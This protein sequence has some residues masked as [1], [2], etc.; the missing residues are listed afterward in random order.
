MKCS[1]W[2]ETGAFSLE[3]MIK[4]VYYSVYRIKMKWKRFNLPQKCLSFT[5][6]NYNRSHY[7]KIPISRYF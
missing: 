7:I 3:K 6:Q 4:N 2:L 5:F 1:G